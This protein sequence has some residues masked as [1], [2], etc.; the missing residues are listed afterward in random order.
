M[1]RIHRMGV[2]EATGEVKEIF[3]LYQRERGNVPNM[4]RT[5]GPKPEILRTLIAHFR[6]VMAP[7][8]IDLRLKELV[9]CAV[10]GIN[11]CEYCLNSHMILAAKAGA[12]ESE[13]AAARDGR[14]ESFA[15]RDRVALEYAAT[16]TR[17]SNGV[18]DQ[19]WGA[20]QE[21]FS[22]EAIIELSTAAGLFN[23]FNRFNN[24]LR[25][26]PTR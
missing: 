17:D 21:H 15:P 14:Y 19:Q 26:P 4:F 22:E 8:E 2:E 12:T 3:D 10:S 5:L 20:L 23:Y 9:V 13:I 6:A 11:R 24:A 25:M 16:L 1:D 18:T 7:G